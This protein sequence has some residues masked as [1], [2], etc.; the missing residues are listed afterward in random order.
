MTAVAIDS[1]TGALV[2][3][4]EKLFPIGLSNPPPRGSRTPAGRDGL[5]EV[6]VN[7]VNFVRTGIE[8]WSFEFLDGQI[9]AQKQLHAAAFAHGV[10]CWLW[11]GTTPNLPAAAGST[12]EQLM[13]R[14]VQAFRDDPALLA[15]KGIDEPRNPFRGPDWIRP[16]G[17]VRAHAKLKS[18]AT[19]AKILRE[20]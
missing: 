4:G 15:W 16:D 12:N 14:I 8:D 3:G 7:G 11:L 19:A 20:G 9:A 18:L 13:T 2:I 10:R 1:A 17:L 5:E 6:G